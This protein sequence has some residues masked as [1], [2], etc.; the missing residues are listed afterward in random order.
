MTALGNMKNNI[1]PK[2]RIMLILTVVAVIGIVWITYSRLSTDPLI[3]GQGSADLSPPPTSNQISRDRPTD[4]VRFDA[5]T[6]VGQIYEDDQTRR[7]QEAQS[8]RGSHVDAIR[9][10]AQENRRSETVEPVVAVEPPPR[11]QSRLEILLEERK[12]KQEEEQQ[13]VAVQRA[14]N[15]AGPAVENPWRQFLGDEKDRAS[16]YSTALS[17]QIGNV[18]SNSVQVVSPTVVAGSNRNS[19][20]ANASPTRSDQPGWERYLNIGSTQP[21]DQVGAI[22]QQ[23]PSQDRSSGVQPGVV[24]S[25]S[26][27]SLDYP[28]ERIARDMTTRTLPSGKINVGEM[29]MG[30]LQI[31]VNTDEISPVRVTIVEQG[32]LNSAVLTGMPE[33]RGESAMIEMTDMSVDRQPY[34][35]RAVLLDPETRRSVIADG[36][37]HHTIERYSKLFVASFVEGFASALSGTQTVTNA[38][39]TSTQTRDALPETSDQIKAGIGKIGEKVSP[40]YERQFNR[41]PTVTVNDNRP[42]LVMFMRAVDLDQPDR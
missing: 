10:Q 39:G 41:P 9:I 26:V 23:Q 3:K 19:N 21:S 8:N 42:V 36:V 15:V 29:Y 38:D 17:L 34:A 13:A 2:A 20:D 6:A 1:P 24:Q 16:G 37:N 40:I 33:L 25:T 12:Q 31:G 4:P 30:V 14:S 22:T 11:A 27:A 7:A 18:R 28:S 5:D 35:I 32:R